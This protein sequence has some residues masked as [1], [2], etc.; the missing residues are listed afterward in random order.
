MKLNG[1]QNDNRQIEENI[2]PNF[3]VEETKTNTATNSESKVGRYD[4]PEYTE[5][6]G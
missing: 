2:K 1:L 5:E 6:V 3:E 4:S